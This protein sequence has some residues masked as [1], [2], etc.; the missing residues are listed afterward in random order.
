MKLSSARPRSQACDRDL[1]EPRLAC[2]CPLLHSPTLFRLVALC[3][4]LPGYRS[5]RELLPEAS[6]EDLTVHHTQRLCCPA[7]RCIVVSHKS[8]KCACWGEVQQGRR[9]EAVGRKKRDD[10][11]LKEVKA[12]NTLRRGI[13]AKTAESP[14]CNGWSGEAGRGEVISAI[15][16]AWKAA[17]W[18]G[19]R[20]WMIS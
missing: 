17:E 7:Q 15:I 19:Y 10:A 4:M 9:W 11:K 2:Y 6:R 3:L 20:S 8:S 1:L 14:L 13:R 16:G 5:F 18:V 12:P